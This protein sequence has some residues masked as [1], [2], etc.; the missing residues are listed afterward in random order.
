MVGPMLDG[1]G[2]RLARQ[3]ARDVHEQVVARAIASGADTRPLVVEAVARQRDAI[4]P[5]LRRGARC[6]GA[7][8]AAPSA[9]AILGS[10]TS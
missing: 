1:R 9:A 2:H 7:P 4:R 6:A 10:E 8:Q 5:A 3:R